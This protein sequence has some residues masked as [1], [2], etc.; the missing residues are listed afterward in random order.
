MGIKIFEGVRYRRSKDLCLTRRMWVFPR[1]REISRVVRGRLENAAK[2][3]IG[4]CR[5][6]EEERERRR[7]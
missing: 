3:L 2:S 6:G 5:G 4:A 1:R 7:K